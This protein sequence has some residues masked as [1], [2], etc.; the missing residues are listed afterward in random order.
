MNNKFSI[1]FMDKKGVELDSWLRQNGH[2]LR[3]KRVFYVVNAKMEQNPNLFK[4][5]LSERGENAAFGRLADYVHFYG[6]E[7][8]KQSNSCHGVKLHV[9]LANVFNPD[10]KTSDSAVRRLETATIAKFK[11]RNLQSENRG[12]ERMRVPIDELFEYLEEKASIED[13]EQITR[14]TPRLV[15]KGQA[16]NQAVKAILSEAKDRQ[17]NQKF[18]VEFMGG[19]KYDT[20]EKQVAYKQPNRKLTYLEIVQLPRGKILVDEFILKNQKKQVADTG[21]VSSR[22]RSAQQVS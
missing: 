6:I 11:D 15:E 5:G 22:T 16:A 20:N 8:S 4:I 9:L 2:K 21:F 14:K 7:N 10:V 18:E 13:I 3:N 19:F 17:G 12:S 1:Q